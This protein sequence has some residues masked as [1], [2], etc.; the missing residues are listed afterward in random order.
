MRCEVKRW[1][2]LS[3]TSAA[4]KSVLLVKLCLAASIIC[5]RL[6]ETRSSRSCIGSSS[7]SLVSESGGEGGL[8]LSLQ[9]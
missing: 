9:G 3:S 6:D 4:I 2:R 5:K 8:L 1:G 7:L